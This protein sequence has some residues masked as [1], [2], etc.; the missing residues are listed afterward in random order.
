M[1]WKKTIQKKTIQIRQEPRVGYVA[2]VRTDNG[3]EVGRGKNQVER[4][5]KERGVNVEFADGI[6]STPYPQPRKTAC[7][8][9]RTPRVRGRS[10]CPK[11]GAEY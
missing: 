4:W 2:Y 5:A 11:C 7:S 8:Y 1:F 10:T 3:Q 6:D 9:C